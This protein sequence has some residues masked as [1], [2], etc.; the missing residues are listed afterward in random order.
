MTTSTLTDFRTH[1]KRHIA[2][3]RRTGEPEILTYRGKPQSVVLTP[4]AYEA[5]AKAV[6]RA[7]TIEMI[8]V[9]AAQCD[10]GLGR[11]F[12]EVFQEMAKKHGIKLPK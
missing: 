10:A 2:R 5:M 8:R 1:T 7:E 3:M 6:E 9:G 4:E 11:P 12:R